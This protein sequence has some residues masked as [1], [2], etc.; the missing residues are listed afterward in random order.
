[1][2]LKCVY[3]INKTQ[4]R[5]PWQQGPADYNLPKTGKWGQQQTSLGDPFYEYLLKEWL[6]SGKIDVEAKQMFDVAATAIEQ[7]LV[8]K[9]PGGLTYIDCRD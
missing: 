5:Q 1:M 7:H 9:S 8:Q 4:K 6:R 3:D 2:C